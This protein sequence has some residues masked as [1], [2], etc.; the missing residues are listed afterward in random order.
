MA[1]V[2]GWPSSSFPYRSEKGRR[3]SPALGDFGVGFPRS[4]SCRSC[5]H[6]AACLRPPAP[7]RS[8]LSLTISTRRFTFELNRASADVA[9]ARAGRLGHTGCE[10]VRAG[11]GQVFRREVRR[12]DLDHRI[13]LDPDLDHVERSAI[14]GHTIPA[15]ALCDLLHSG[16]VG[17]DAEREVRGTEAAPLPGLPDKAAAF[18]AGR[19]QFGAGRINLNPGA[20]IVEL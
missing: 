2:H 16:R 19:L 4:P 5:R 18:L 8:V 3:L 9:G 6:P 1:S 14:T 17:R 13:V 20:V 11:P 12:Q 15:G 7:H 10:G